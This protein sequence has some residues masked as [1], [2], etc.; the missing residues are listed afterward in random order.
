MLR[1]RAPKNRRVCGPNKTR[2][3][4][5]VREDL[6]QFFSPFFETSV[7]FD[8]LFD[9]MSRSLGETN[10]GNYPPYDLLQTGDDAY[11]IVMA[12]AG[13]ESSQLDLTL[14]NNVLTVSGEKA[15]TPEDSEPEYVHRGIANRGFKQ[16]FNLAEHV[17]VDSA[18]LKNGLLRV[19]LRREVPEALKPQTIPVTAL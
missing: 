7:G 13:F 1:T 4:A 3:R 17:C 2:N 11:E 15:T 8:R 6:S 10:S 18:S 16:R 5:P 19:S 12:V 9:T 14:E